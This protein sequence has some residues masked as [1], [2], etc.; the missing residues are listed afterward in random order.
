MDPISRRH[1]WDAIEAAKPGRAIVLTTHS[2]EEADIL[3][4]SVAIMA[5][6]RVRAFGSSLRL[7]QR[8]GSGYQLAVAVAGAK[9]LAASASAPALDELPAAD[10]GGSG[11]GAAAAG[12]PPE[13]LR[14]V[15]GVT[16]LFAS[17]LGVPAAEGSSGAYLLFLVPKD[18]EPRLPAFLRRLERERAALGVTDVQISLTSLEEVF[19]N[20]ARQAELDAAAAEGRDDVAVT[21]EDGSTLEVPLGDEFAT[22]AG[23]GVT[24][25]IKWAQDE[26][27]GLQVLSW[28]PV[29]EGE[30]AGARDASGGASGGGAAAARARPSAAAV[31]PEA[32]APMARD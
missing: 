24:Y 5:R 19:L 3:G 9:S 7:K 28:T 12:A 23:T 29:G 17:E 30:G 21:L 2:M 4:D 31:A 11:A 6:G 32:A 13:V 22:Q 27:G 20:I 18:R 26:A 14:R 10:G 16:A 1:V 25:A 15:A 8:F